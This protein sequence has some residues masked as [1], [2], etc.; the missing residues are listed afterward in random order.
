MKRPKHNNVYIMKD[1]SQQMVYIPEKENDRMQFGL[2]ALADNVIHTSDRDLGATTVASVVIT[3]M[4]VVFMALILL[5]AL[6]SIYGAVFKSI[7]KKAAE[8]AAAEKAAKEAEKPKE[9]SS[10]KA[11]APAPAVEDGI[12]EEIVAVITA[13]IAAYGANSGKTLAVKSIRRSGSAPS[14]RSAWGS[15]GLAEATRPF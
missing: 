12:E 6:V 15:A 4:A 14:G 9:S 2:L 13:A 1:V 7:N 3:G 11:A 8:K 5:I 10:V